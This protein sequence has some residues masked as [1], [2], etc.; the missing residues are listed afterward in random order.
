M[1]NILDS[2]GMKLCDKYTIETVGIPSMVL[3]ERAALSVVKEIE[4][5]VKVTKATVLVVAG[6]GNNGGDGIAIGRILAMKGAKVS[7]HLVGKYEKCS[8]E[9][10]QQINIIE[11]LGYSL[12]NDN[13]FDEQEY[14]IVIDALFGIGLSRKVEGIYEKAICDI[15]KFGK[16]G[17][18]YAVDVPSGINGDTGEIMGVAVKAQKT[19]TFQYPK[20][21]L[22]LYPGSDYTGKVIV[23][24]IGISSIPIERKKI[25]P[26]FYSYTK[27][28]RKLLPKR[29]DAGNKG[30]FGRVCVIAGSENMAG[31]ACFSA[32]AA[33][34]S[35]CGLVEVVT[36]ESNRMILQEKIPE[37]ILTT[38]KENESEQQRKEK[39]LASMARAKAIVLGPGLGTTKVSE[40]IVETV[41][42]NASVPC[43]ID[44]DALNILSKHLE[45]LKMCEM[46]C[47]LTPH[48]KELSRLCHLAME[49]V[50]SNYPQIALQFA[51][52][53][54]C[55]VVAKNA[56]TLV[57]SPIENTPYLN[58]SGCNGMATAGS[59]DVLTGIIAGL[60]AQG[61]Q[62][63][64]STCM[65][66][67]LH[68]LA[69]EEA[70]KKYGN[71]SMKAGNIIENL[72]K[73]F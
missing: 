1:L 16:S 20:A 15:N 18:I 62:Y 56:R 41:M 31:A 54:E 34:R 43:I 22:Y 47:I 44:A 55:V 53:Y 65:G 38:Y 40:E 11:N 73:A 26:K 45:W 19:I 9:T 50:K 39:I 4:K 61:G 32:D 25:I 46:P 63:Y 14:T 68:G 67:Y 66:V 36:A 35:G 10:K 17:R 7:F 59:G 6:C 60:I 13:I 37:A 58:L 28:D 21:G 57:A 42:K 29:K 64:E 72:Y 49:E 2:N 51:K 3:M 70:A 24:D 5:D 30:T 52:E 23:R 48:L 27:E 12:K 69:G 33:Y 71:Y 8:Q